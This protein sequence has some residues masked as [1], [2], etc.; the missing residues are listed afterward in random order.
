MLWPYQW[1][2]CFT[3]SDP[4]KLFPPGIRN[5]SLRTE[6]F[7]SREAG[8]EHSTHAGQG[9]LWL[10][11]HPSACATPTCSDPVLTST[12]LFS[13]AANPT[14]LSSPGQE[15]STPF[16]CCLSRLPLVPA[17]THLFPSLQNLTDT[18]QEKKQP[19]WGKKATKPTHLFFRNM[20]RNCSC[21]PPSN[22]GGGCYYTQH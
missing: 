13:F 17:V 4:A 10:R 7:R 3:E 14:W 19:L 12:C 22:H 6:P 8:A 9:D 16:F 5:F 11:L 21:F 15:H 1:A 2:A 20:C 18:G